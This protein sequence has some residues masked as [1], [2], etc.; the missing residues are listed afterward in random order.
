MTKQKLGHSFLVLAAKKFYQDP[1][2]SDTK[3][4]SR[5]GKH[6]IIKKNKN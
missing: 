6:A 5:A 3:K 1:S 4:L 2:T